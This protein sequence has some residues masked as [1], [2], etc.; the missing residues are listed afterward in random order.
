[1][2]ITVL[3]LAWPRLQASIRYLPVEIGIERYLA[4]GDIPTERLPVLI[5]FSKEA[6]EHQDHY[7]YHDGLS[8]LHLMRAVDLQTPARERRD[9]YLAAA[10]EAQQSLQRAPAQPITWLRLARLRWILRKEHQT[11][12]EAWKMSVFS[13]RTTI[14]LL[15]QRVEIGLAYRAALDEE[16]VA[17]LRDQILLA[18]RLIPGPL[19]NM[20]S[21]RDRNLNVTRPLIKDSDP[22][23]LADIEAWLAKLP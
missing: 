8:Q 23:A 12:V 20:L 10:S 14:T 5:R 4:T 7:R 6:I 18:W 15:K 22:A 1:M 9:A 21:T 16:G 13:G 2:A 11:V 17:M 3:V 19:V